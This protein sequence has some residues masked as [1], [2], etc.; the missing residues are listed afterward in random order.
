MNSVDALCH[1][2]VFKDKPVSVFMVVKSPA[3][4]AKVCP[5]DS[6]HRYCK[7]SLELLPSSQAP[8]TLD[9]W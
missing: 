6:V 7:P 4:L 9:Y 8:S 5:P 3:S 2:P 1:F